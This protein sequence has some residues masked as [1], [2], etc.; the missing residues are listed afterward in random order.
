MSE[1][2]G[3]YRMIS[4]NLFG[5]GETS[6]WSSEKLQ[7]LKDSADLVIALANRLEGPLSLIGH[8][9]GGSV[10]MKAA[11]NLEERLRSLVLIEPNPFYLLKD[12]GRIEAYQEICLLGDFVKKF[13]ALGEWNRVASQ[14]VNYWNSDG[15]W[16]ALS[17][18]RKATLT[19]MVKPNFHEWD[20]VLDGEDDILEWQRLSTRMLILKGSETRRAITEIV[21]FLTSALPNL[22]SLEV[23]GC[24]H[25]L[26]I[27]HP[28]LVNPIIEKFLDR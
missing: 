25:M 23:P 3:R 4:M 20:A 1:M 22:N 21:E 2:S 18:E 8:S 7:T 17:E 11:L 26:P 15:A 9:F 14:F 10:A 16:E 6:V 13:G 12:Y 24:G 19:E 5:Y 27:T 28:H